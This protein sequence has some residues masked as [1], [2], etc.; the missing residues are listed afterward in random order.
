MLLLS[1][2]GKAG[3]QAASMIRFGEGAAPADALVVSGRIAAD[4][5]GL[6]HFDAEVLFDKIDRCENREERIPFTAAGPPDLADFPQ[7][8]GGHPVGQGKGLVRQR[9]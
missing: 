3:G 8:G 7:G 2:S 4:D 1:D 9:R 6:L 5:G